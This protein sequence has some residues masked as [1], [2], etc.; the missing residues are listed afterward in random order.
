MHTQKLLKEIKR[1]PLEER[2]LL[3]EEA[4]KSIEKEKLSSKLQYAAELLHEDYLSDVELTAF[5]TIDYEH[6]YETR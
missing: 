6:F 3:V 4:L 1:L 5:T 2:Y